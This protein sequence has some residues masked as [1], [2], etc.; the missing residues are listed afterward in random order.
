MI[1]RAEEAALN[2]AFQGGF[3]KE[4]TL[5]QGVPDRGN[6]KCKV[7]VHWEIEEE[8]GGWSA[9][10]QE[11]NARGEGAARPWGLEHRGPLEPPYGFE[12]LL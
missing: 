9:V 8:Q 3:P 4:E 1:E 10:C 7:P 6:C 12:H 11:G 2:L 5:E